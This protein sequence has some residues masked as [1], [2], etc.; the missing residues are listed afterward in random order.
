MSGV[1]LLPGAPDCYE[2]SVMTVVTAIGGRM[3]AARRTAPTSTE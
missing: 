3:L 1:I 2:R